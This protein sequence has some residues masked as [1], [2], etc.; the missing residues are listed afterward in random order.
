VPLPSLTSCEQSGA[1]AS[2]YIHATLFFHSVWRLKSPVTLVGFEISL[3]C[4]LPFVFRFDYELTAMQV[5][6]FVFRDTL[7][8]MPLASLLL[9]YS[10]LSQSVTFQLSLHLGP[11]RPGLPGLLLHWSSCHVLP[12]T[13]TFCRCCIWPAP[14]DQQCWKCSSAVILRPKSKCQCLIIARYPGCSVISL[15]CYGFRQDCSQ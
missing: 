3:L 11:Y 12:V 1:A 10:Y 5:T 15:F 13:L 2:H 8:A 9:P 7:P 14:I 6:C 4:L